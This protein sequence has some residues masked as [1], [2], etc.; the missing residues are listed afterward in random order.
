MNA[1]EHILR[2]WQQNAGPWVRSIAEGAI[3]SRRLVTDHAIVNAITLLHPTRVWDIGC[4]EGWLC[5]ELQHRGIETIGTDAIPALVDAARQQGKGRYEVLAY[6]QITSDVARQWSADCYVFNFSLFGHEGVG[7]LL[8]QLHA[9][10][11][12]SGNLVIQ[13]LHPFTAL[14]A[15][16]YQSGWRQGSWDGFSADFVDPAPWYYRTLSHWI[17]LLQGTGYILRSLQEPIHPHTGLPA[18]LILI[19]GHR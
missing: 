12:T 7:S 6:D 19:A 10:L 17:D 4:G 5:R 18:S 8:Q 16:P 13:T 11:P 9:T 2:T 3:E 14:G 15:G 1:E